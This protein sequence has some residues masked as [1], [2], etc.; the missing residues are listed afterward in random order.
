MVFFNLAVIIS[1]PIFYPYIMS[2]RPEKITPI[3][4]TP[5]EASLQHEVEN[6]TGTL[7]VVT[8]TTGAGKN[9]LVEQI[10]TQEPQLRLSRIVSYTTRPQRP[11]EVEGI[12]YHFVS[13]DEFEQL[14]ASGAFFET[15]KSTGKNGKENSYGT[16]KRDLERV[17]AGEN[18][19]WIIDLFRAANLERYIED[20]FGDH[21]QEILKRTQVITV[22]A[23]LTKIKDRFL[24][25]EQSSTNAR[26]M[27]LS[28]IRKDWKIYSQNKNKFPEEN[29]VINDGSLEGA[30]HKLKSKI[31]QLLSTSEETQ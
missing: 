30:V 14:I 18:M 23:P 16:L 22:G 28:R 3:L 4:Q 24:G 8:G 7:I 27:F 10:L 6:K 20:Q 15:S 1:L 21:A 12:D 26:E 31:E 17:L 13:E 5:I 29:V 9:T 25:R 19:V 2:L 11:G